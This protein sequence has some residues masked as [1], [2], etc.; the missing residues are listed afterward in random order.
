MV[1]ILTIGRHKKRME[2]PWLSHR[3]T[4]GARCVPTYLCFIPDTRLK[5]EVSS[6]QI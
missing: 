1:S 5:L 6:Q 3:G 2:K 4:P